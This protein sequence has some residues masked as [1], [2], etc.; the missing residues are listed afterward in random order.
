M[1][2]IDSGKL[3]LHQFNIFLIM[4]YFDLFGIPIQLKV[5]NAQ[6]HKR[7]I[8]LSRKF[9]PDYFINESSSMQTDALENSAA[10]NKAYKTFKN[11]EETIRYVLMEKNLME[12]EEKYELPAEF[13]MEMLELNEQ[14]M[15]ADVEEEREKLKS[16]LQ[17][18]ESGI[19]EP[20]KN[21]I[22]NYREAATSAEELL[23][24][25]EY[26]YKKKYLDRIRQQ[27]A[28]KA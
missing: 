16:D 2:F 5:D 11:M 21:I 22:E 4:K 15:E 3:I 28:G 18:I 1:I 6:L 27:L 17:N 23:Q 25:K 10:L 24:V 14:M 20:V 13:L 9:H 8:E 19:Y 26:Y 7:Y 12:E